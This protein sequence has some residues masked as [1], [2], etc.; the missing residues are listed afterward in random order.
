[1]NFLRKT[2]WE[3][4]PSDFLDVDLKKG[5]LHTWGEYPVGRE[6]ASDYAATLTEGK[7]PPN[8]KG[9]FK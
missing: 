3:F 2:P 7:N 4:N 1:M 9:A 8:F 5:G 6:V